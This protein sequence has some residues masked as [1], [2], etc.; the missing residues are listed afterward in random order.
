MKGLSERSLSMDN[1]ASSY[2]RFRDN[3]DRNGL[4]R[5]SDA[6]PDKHRRKHLDSGGADRGN[7]LFA[8]H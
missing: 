6:I 1:G 7:F 3:G 4:Q 5:R 8:W 2:R